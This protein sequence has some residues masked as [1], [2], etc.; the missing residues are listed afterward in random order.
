MAN[1]KEQLRRFWMFLAVLVVSAIVRCTMRMTITGEKN[2]P[3]T[4]GLLLAAN[5]VSMLD[6][7]L[8]AW[9]FLKKF[10]PTPLYAPA[11][12]EL[13]RN[14]IMG[15]LLR[16]LSVFP[17]RRNGRDL[18]SIRKLL[19]LLRTHKV[20]MFPEGTRSPT[21]EL[22]KGNR[23]VGRLV[24]ES[25]PVVIPVA[26]VGTQQIL[27]KGEILPRLFCKVRLDFGPAV[28]LDSCYHLPACKE[29]YEEIVHRIMT[30]I[31]L[32]LGKHHQG[33]AIRKMAEPE[34]VGT[35]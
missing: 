16:S 5:H 14:P 17:V 35:P 30:A 12:E 8:V 18:A 4:E 28:D 10:W 25:R 27:P 19:A 33:D 31:S 7:M 21:G 22:G 9:A 15:P 11:K 32:Q 23:V 20:M 24:Y 29:T 2:I 6:P 34:M 26:V 13:F 3:S 1:I